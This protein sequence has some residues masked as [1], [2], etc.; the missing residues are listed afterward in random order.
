MM[1]LKI[2]F[3]TLA[4]AAVL[5]G[6]AAATSGFSSALFASPPSPLFKGQAF[7][8][9]DAIAAGVCTAGGSATAACW[10]NGSS[11][12]ATGVGIAASAS[13]TASTLDLRDGSGNVIAT[14]T[15]A[16]GKTAMA[17]DTAVATGQ[18]AT[19]HIPYAIAH[20]TVSLGTTTVSTG[21]CSSAIDGGT[22]T[23]VLTTDVVSASANA[24]PTGVTGYKPAT[25]GT[26]YV[27]AYP[28][29]DH[30]NFKLCNNTSADITPGSAVTLNWYAL[31]IQ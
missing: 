9:T 10:Y 14:N 25:T 12:V 28:T 4:F 17:T 27:W 13:A 15:V 16:A 24:D 5:H 11:W 3:V 2:L 22:A 23:G 29:S 26:L 31:R 20:G 19:A 18:L 6:Q 21:T 7:M 30:V 8:F 1:R